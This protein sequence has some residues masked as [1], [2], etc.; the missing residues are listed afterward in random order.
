MVDISDVLIREARPE[1]ADGMIAYLQLACAEPNNQVVRGPGEFDYTVE[2]EQEIIRM[3]AASGNSIFIVADANGRIVG[4]AN[5]SG[6][7]FQA[8]RHNGSLGISLHPD[9]RDRGLGTRMMQYLIDWARANPLLTRVELEV[10]ARN[11]RAMRV[12]EKAGFTQEGIR[13]NAFIKDGEYV[14]SVVMGLLL[15]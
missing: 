12:Y 11:A 5:I 15:F 9:Y 3:A 1:D 6:G 8:N 2:E 13:R 14:D 7:R 10:F 4:V